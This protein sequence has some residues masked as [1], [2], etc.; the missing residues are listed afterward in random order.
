MDYKKGIYKELFNDML[1]N[2]I[3][4]KVNGIWSKEEL[5]KLQ[6][7]EKKGYEPNTYI[8]LLGW[9]SEAM[10]KDEI[11]WDIPQVEFMYKGLLG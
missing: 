11:N 9:Y 5:K 4:L 6:D 1:D 10:E 3:E 2:L 7:L 8:I